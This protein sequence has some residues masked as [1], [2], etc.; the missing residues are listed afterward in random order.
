MDSVVVSDSLQLHQYQ[1]SI[2]NGVEFVRKDI[3]LRGFI[4]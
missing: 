2:K 1:V 3:R 4:D